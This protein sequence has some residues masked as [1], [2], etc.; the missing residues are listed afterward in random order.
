MADSNEITPS[1]SGPAPGPIEFAV[2]SLEDRLRAALG[3][4]IHVRETRLIGGPSAVE[5]ALRELAEC[6]RELKHTGDVGERV[7]LELIGFPSDRE[8][9]RVVSA[10][11]SKG[12]RFAIIA[13]AVAT[14]ITA[15]SAII[16]AW[17][18]P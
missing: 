12:K 4:V 18:K 10:G 13:G 9:R 16:S 15:I 11:A 6:F 7:C 2:A 14:L 17:R 5:V 3:A 1:R 8:I